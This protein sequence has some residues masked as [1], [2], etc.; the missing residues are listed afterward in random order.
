MVGL[1]YFL[2][3]KLSKIVQMVGTVLYTPDTYTLTG[4]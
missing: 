4:I 2:S 1:I 3:L